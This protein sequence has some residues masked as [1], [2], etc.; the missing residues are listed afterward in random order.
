MLVLFALGGYGRYRD[1][2]GQLETETLLVEIADRFERRLARIASCYRPRED[3]FAALVPEPSQAAHEA[4]ASALE[5]LREP[6][7]F[8]S[9]TAAL[10]MVSV[11]NEA[12]EPIAAL[13]TA[14]LRLARNDPERLPRDRRRAP[15]RAVLG[16]VAQE[17]PFSIR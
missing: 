13:K 15:R 3:E 12:A 2:F 5:A 17:S 7:R 1:Y 6:G 11:P 10:G 16:L 4:I 8:V 9:I 14:D